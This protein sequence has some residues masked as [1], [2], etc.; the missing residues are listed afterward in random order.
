MGRSMPICE[1]QSAVVDASTGTKQSFSKPSTLILYF[2]F[3]TV[4]FSLHFS[5]LLEW[6]SSGALTTQTFFSR[7]TTRRPRRGQGETAGRLLEDH[8]KI[9]GTLGETIGDHMG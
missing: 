6:L 2:L 9:R 8:R 1:T 7:V 3:H 4:A 5:V